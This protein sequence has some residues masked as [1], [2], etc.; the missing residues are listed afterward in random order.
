MKERK[1]R[2]ERGEKEEVHIKLDTYLRG[3]DG[4]GDYLG[5]KTFAQGIYMYAP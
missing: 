4:G 2:K 5:P 1:G 3:Y